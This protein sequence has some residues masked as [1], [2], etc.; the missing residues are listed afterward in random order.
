MR[1]LRLQLM[2]LLGL[3]ITLATMV[4]LGAS[5]RVAM[6]EANKLFDYHMRQMALALQDS[7]LEQ[8][9]LY[10]VS[11]PEQNRFEFVVQIWTDSGL[12]VYQAH[13]YRL[14]PEQGGTGYANVELENGDWRVYTARPN[15]RVIQVAQ[16][17]SER[18]ERAMS[19]ALHSLWPVIAV[20]ILLLAATWWVITWVLSPIDRIGQELATRDAG[21][22]TPVS[23]KGIPQEIRSLVGELN[24]LLVRM[25]QALQSQQRFVADAAHELRSPLTALKLQVQTL[26]RARTDNAREQAVGRLQGGID[27]ASRLVEQLLLLARENPSAREPSLAEISLTTCIAQAMSDVA[28][29]AIAKRIELRES[30]P[31][32]EVTVTGDAESLRVLVR[33]LLDNGVRYTPETGVVA[34]SVTQDAS[35]VRLSVEDSGPGIATEHRSRVFDQFFRIP[36]T[37]ATGSGLGLA[38]VK[39]IAERHHA[40]VELDRAA[41]GGLA[42][43]LLL[44]HPTSGSGNTLQLHVRSS[45]HDE[46][47]ILS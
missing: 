9:K 33:N 34:V 15:S 41:L 10:P 21:S 26:A 16:K 38:I 7:T 35:G 39:A 28:P 4:Q 37:T 2:L 6:Q 23:D 45:D 8:T 29:L 3:A 27:R 20:S 5:F 31:V 1:S 14:L 24:S 43:K 47:Q 25:D 40:L 42:V 17:L 11:E 30:V 13:P 32:E 44:P 12:R 46:P 36:G 22:L 18:R 19:L